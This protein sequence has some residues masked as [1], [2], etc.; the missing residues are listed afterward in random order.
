MISQSTARRFWPRENPIGKRFKLDLEFRGKWTEFEVVGIARD[1]RFA[2]L[3]RIDPSHVYVPTGVKDF[4]GIVVRSQGDPARAIISVRRAVEEL[5]PDLLPT[6][7]F[8]TIENGPL[9]LQR[10]MAQIAAMYAGALAFV[11]LM[12]A[13]AGI[14]GVMSYLVNQRVKE[15]RI[16]MALGS[17]AATVLKTVVLEGL[18]PAFWGI[19]LGALG[20]AALSWFVHTSLAFPG[21]ADFFYGVRFY[22]PVTFLGLSSVFILIAAIAAFV[23]AQRAIKVDPLVALRYE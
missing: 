10:S 19:G 22:D 20:A 5:D 17:T 14:Y 21:A 7:W 16:R 2:N 3:T 13:A 6:L 4:Y 8:R 1:V 15:I 9:H 18:H 23:P 11:A 12:L